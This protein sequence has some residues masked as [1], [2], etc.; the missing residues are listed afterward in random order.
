MSEGNCENGWRLAGL[1][2]RLDVIMEPDFGAGI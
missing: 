1:D 2:F